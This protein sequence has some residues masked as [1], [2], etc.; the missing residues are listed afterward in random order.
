M[1]YPEEFT[2]KVKKVGDVYTAYSPEI[3]LKIGDDETIKASEISIP[4]VL[5]SWVNMAILNDHP[6]FLGFATKIFDGILALFY[7]RKTKKERELEEKIRILT[8]IIKG[9]EQTLRALPTAATYFF[10]PVGS[11]ATMDACSVSVPIDGTISC[12]MLSNPFAD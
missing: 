4:L 10:N 5:E 7:L 1:Y 11:G 8:N 6:K 2:I 3:S 12:G 9:K